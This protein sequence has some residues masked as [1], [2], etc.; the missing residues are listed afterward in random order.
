MATQPSPLFVPVGTNSAQLF[1]MD[2][3]T[4][5]CRLATNMGL[6]CADGASADRDTVLANMRF[7]WDPAWLREIS[8]RPGTVLMLGG[9]P[10]LA[11]VATGSDAQA[12][13]HAMSSEGGSLN[14][15]E[16]IDGE[17]AELSN[18]QLS[19]TRTPVRHASGRFRTRSRSSAPLMTL[20]TRA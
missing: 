20:P 11:H 5:A 6:E 1:G 17:T 13:A 9:N 15:L 19:E 10:V 2:A 3:R 16:K 8:G 18:S 7:A 4:R 14:G 12:V